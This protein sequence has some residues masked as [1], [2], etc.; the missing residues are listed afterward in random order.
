LIII[1]MDGRTDATS[2]PT[3]LS[4]IYIYIFIYSFFS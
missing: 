4:I 2:I 1:R 3:P